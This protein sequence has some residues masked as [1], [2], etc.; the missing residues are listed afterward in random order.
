MSEKK[1]KTRIQ[2]K[3]DIEANWIKANNSSTPFVPMAGEIIIYDIE[4][5]ADGSPLELPDGRT[6]AYTYERIK[7][8]DGKT[9]ISNLPFVSTKL[10]TSGKVSADQ[11][12]AASG[13]QAGITIV[14]P[15]DKCSTFTSDS[16]TVTP[17][18]VQ[19]GAKMFAITRPTSA[20]ANAI[21]RY[22]DNT[23]NVKD[24][25]III[26]DVTN[27]QNSSKTAQVIAIPAEGNKKM[28]YG[29]C[30]DQVDGTSF[31]GGLF[32]AD[33]TKYPYAQGLAIGGTSGNL[34]WKGTKVATI[35]DI[36]SA[37]TTSTAGLMSAADKQKL[38]N[39]A[40]GA[41]NY[42]LPAA[43]SSTLGGVKISFDPATG[44]LSI[45]T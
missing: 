37:A 2:Q 17:K 21:T 30:T 15:A 29:Y 25:K 23:G 8:G 22:S 16:G 31:L 12:P 35:A 19:K 27:T 20:T 14:Y 45:S 33:A 5:A 9:T 32:D 36:P 38:N 11:L 28:V 3:H 39:I 34:L 44:T 1:V 24:S 40:S 41:N 4:I 18:A 13:T 7:I 42:T 43:T 26:E 6:T 10:D